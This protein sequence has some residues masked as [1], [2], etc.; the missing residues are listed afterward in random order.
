MPW[1]VLLNT[2][3]VH[4]CQP[5]DVRLVCKGNMC[6]NWKSTMVPCLTSGS[7]KSSSLHHTFFS[8]E[9]KLGLFLFIVS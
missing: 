2:P 4:K 6:I 7:R 1:A 9:H 5:W 3:F 8:L